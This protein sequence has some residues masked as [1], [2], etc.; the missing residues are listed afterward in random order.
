MGKKQHRMSLKWLQPF[1]N[2]LADSPHI[3]SRTIILFRFF[4]S[5]SSG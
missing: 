1:Y 2:P 5:H 4:F 3:P